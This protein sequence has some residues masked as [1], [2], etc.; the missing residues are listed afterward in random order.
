M[1]H[2]IIL[3]P[4]ILKGTLILT[5]MKCVRTM[6][7]YVL[8][9]ITAWCMS[10]L[11]TNYGVCPQNYEGCSKSFCKHNPNKRYKRI[12]PCRW[13]FKHLW[14][15]CKNFIHFHWA[16]LELFAV[17]YTAVYYGII[18]KLHFWH[19]FWWQHFLTLKL[20]CKILKIGQWIKSPESL[21]S[22]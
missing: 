4:E 6:L 2:K 7:V 3:G 12:L 5:K 10:S 18:K 1:G 19:I 21:L 9:T 15:H 8:R 17:I 11:R 14:V 22:P 13:K 20:S 16:G